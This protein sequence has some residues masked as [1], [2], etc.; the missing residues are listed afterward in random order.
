[1]IDEWF[2]NTDASKLF[3]ILQNSYQ[4]QV[5]FALKIT[6]KHENLDNCNE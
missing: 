1:M 5:T 2:E 6:T 4:R 3:Y